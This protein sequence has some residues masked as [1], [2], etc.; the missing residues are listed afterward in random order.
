MTRVRKS[1]KDPRIDRPSFHHATRSPQSRNAAREAILLCSAPS[2]ESPSSSGFLREEKGR[3][4]EVRRGESWE[5]R[6]EMEVGLRAGEDD[7]EG[8]ISHSA[9]EAHN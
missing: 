7:S 5:K 4:M 9:K 2:G 8:L 3:K 1:L 6:R